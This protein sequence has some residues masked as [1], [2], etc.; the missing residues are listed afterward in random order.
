[1]D[2]LFIMPAL[3]SPSVP[4]R[5]IPGITKMVE[6]NNLLMNSSS[7]RV[8]AM[9]RYASWFRTVKHESENSLVEEDVPGPSRKQKKITDPDYNKDTGSQS[10]GSGRGRKTPD[11]A[12]K[13]ILKTGAGIGKD[14]L[15]GGTASDKGGQ[16]MPR[17]KPGEIEYPRGVSFFN[18]I[19]LE[20]TI[21]E[22]VIS[23]KRDLVKFSGT[24]DR[25]IRI[26]MK[27]VPYMVDGVTDLKNIIYDVNKLNKVKTYFQ[28]RIES[29]KKR[30]KKETRYIY[31][32]VTS[33]GDPIKDIILGPSSEDLANPRILASLMTVLNPA[34]WSSLI[35]FTTSDFKNTEMRDMMKE[36]RNLVKSG[37]GDIVIIDENKEIVHFC[38]AK[39]MACTFLPFTYLRQ[40][41]NMEDVIDYRETSSYTKAFN[42]SPLRRTFRNISN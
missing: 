16:D 26:G 13:F 7:M 31:K 37:W 23:Q 32:G 25:I 30:W 15:S 42:I 1:M 4:D 19:S 40:I 33:T 20:P 21:L 9:M 28:R 17:M 11:D 34:R 18:S 5:L 12:E 3:I 38:T 36:Y 29:F 24:S 22:M 10:G 14:A 2:A 41:L 35:V 27:A 6:R 39:M 8:A